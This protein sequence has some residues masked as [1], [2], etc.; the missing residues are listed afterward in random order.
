[1]G[2]AG[3]SGSMSARVRRLVWFA[4]A[5]GSQPA[6]RLSAK[7]HA[8]ASGGLDETDRSEAGR[9]RSAP[10]AVSLAAKRLERSALPLASDP[11]A[12]LPLSRTVE[13]FERLLAEPEPEPAGDRD[14]PLAPEQL[15]RFAAVLA[16]D[17]GRWRHLVRHERDVRVYEQIFCDERVSAWLICWSDRQDTGFHDHDESAGGIAVIAGRVCEERL[18][19]G[20]PPLAR[21][22]SAGEC[23]N[24]PASAIHRVVHAGAEP[25]ITIHAYS[26]PLARMGAY[27]IGPGGELEREAISHE[28]E[29]RA[30]AAAA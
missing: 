8:R 10:P 25:A 20:S 21:T 23:F 15:E 22:L 29:L 6:A 2:S 27:R 28:Q 30:E 13:R 9:Q 14:A 5:P 7:S 24:V 4:A 17:P 1:M 16:A 12:H 11:T 18:A 19:V 26:P 3:G